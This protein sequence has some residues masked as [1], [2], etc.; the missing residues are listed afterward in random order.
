M[1]IENFS[2]TSHLNLAVT[3]THVSNIKTK[4][5]LACLSIRTLEED[6]GFKKS[7]ADCIIEN[8]SLIVLN[9]G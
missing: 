6:L 8:I 4:Q 7:F 3:Q 2:I 5:I 9:G 1:H